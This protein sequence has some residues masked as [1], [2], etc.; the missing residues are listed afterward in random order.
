MDNY[1]GTLIRLY[2]Y[3]QLWWDTDPFIHLLTSVY[4][5]SHK[6]P[7]QILLKYATKPV[8]L[9]KCFNVEYIFVY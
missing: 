8:S 5:K 3:G 4:V 2:I 6:K 7:Y 1:D 9:I